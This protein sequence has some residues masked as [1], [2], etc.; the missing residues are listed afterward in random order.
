MIDPSHV[1]IDVGKQ[2]NYLLTLEQPCHHLGFAQHVGI[3][4]SGDTV[5]AGF[6]SV[7]ADGWRCRID[8]IHKID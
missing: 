2:Q 7:T 3:T 4:R 8:R 1:I 6:D 5:Y